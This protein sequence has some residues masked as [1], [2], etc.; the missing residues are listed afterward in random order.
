[1]WTYRALFQLLVVSVGGRF[2]FGL[3][4]ILPALQLLQ[5][6]LLRGFASKL[7]VESKVLPL[8]QKWLS[9]LLPLP[10]HYLDYC[11]QLHSVDSQ[12]RRSFN[13]LPGLLVLAKGSV[14]DSPVFVGEGHV[15]V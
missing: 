7:R 3:S 10:L 1:M 4:Y 15:W 14:S 13:I 8:D 6:K 9:T 12:F 2:F 11:F 5:S